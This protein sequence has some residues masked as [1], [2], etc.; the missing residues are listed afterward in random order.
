MV[1]G[2]AKLPSFH[3]LLPCEVYLWPDARSYTRQPTVEIQTL[4]SPPLLEGLLRAACAA[5]ARLA[6]PGEFTLRAFLAGRLDLTQAEAVLGV[7]DAVDRRELNVALAQLAGGLS[8]ALQDLRDELLDILARIEAGLDFVEEEIEFVTTGEIDR[9]LSRADAAASGLLRRMSSRGAIGDAVRAVLVGS[10][11][12]GKS[13]LFNALVGDAAAIVSTTA[14]TT[15]DFLIGRVDLDGVVCELIDTAGVNPGHLDGPAQQDLSAMATSDIAAAAQYQS[16]Q[17]HASAHVRI[18]CLD[19]SRMLNDW[20]RAEL[21][22]TGPHSLVALT[23]C[24]RP[25]KIESL[26]SAIATSSLTDQG[27]DELRRRLRETVVAAQHVDADVVGATAVRCHDSLRRAS[28]ALAQAREMLHDR[29]GE[30]LIAA[31]IRLA[32]DELGHVTGAVYSDDVL[33]RIF[34]RFCIGK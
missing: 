19:S 2:F 31:E 23:K 21:H 15:R 22:R 4:G 34:S 26:D 16:F 7:V 28:A 12:V 13:S 9:A 24:D 17:Q 5:G 27:L 10:P 1:A 25:L 30:E 32:L 33:D 29:V 3:S 18:L 6:E 14:G 20:E 11:N 8:G